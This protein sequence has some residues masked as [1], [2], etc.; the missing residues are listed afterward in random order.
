MSIVG[1]KKSVFHKSLL[2]IFLNSRSKLI[3]KKK[4]YQSDQATAEYEKYVSETY[5]IF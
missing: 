1:K 3:K 4:Y 5:T 2:I